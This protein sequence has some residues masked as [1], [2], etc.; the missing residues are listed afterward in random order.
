MFNTRTHA[1]EYPI[2]PKTLKSKLFALGSE[3]EP[4]QRHPETTLGMINEH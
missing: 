1:S 3:H 4:Y 2:R